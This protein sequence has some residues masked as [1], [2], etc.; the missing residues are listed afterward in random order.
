[1]G[2]LSSHL[3]PAVT[4]DPANEDHRR[5]FAEYLKTGTWGKCPVVFADSF[6]GGNQFAIIQRRLAEYYLQKEFN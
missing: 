4:F 2:I 5:Y 3:R 6:Q 1:M